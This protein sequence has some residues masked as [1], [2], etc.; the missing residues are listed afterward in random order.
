[1]RSADVSQV[2]RPTADGVRFLVKVKPRS[3]QTGPRGVRGE[4]WLW[5]VKSAPVEGA[6]NEELRERIAELLGVPRS[7]V[8]IL[9]GETSP[10]KLIEVRGVSAHEVTRHCR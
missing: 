7:C 2:V 6:A 5:G 10:T 4:E 1:M 3:S 9:R 8:Q